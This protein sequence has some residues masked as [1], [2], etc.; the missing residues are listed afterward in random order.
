M[1]VLFAVG[2]ACIAG[3]ITRSSGHLR[4]LMYGL[5]CLVEGGGWGEVVR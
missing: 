3:R 5:R 1:G 4:L 2:R